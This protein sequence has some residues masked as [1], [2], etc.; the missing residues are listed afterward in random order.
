MAPLCSAPV[1]GCPVGDS[2]AP[3]I[4][5]L[6]TDPFLLPIASSPSQ[7]PGG[8]P[9]L[10]LL[11]LLFMASL[12]PGLP[13][14]PSDSTLSCGCKTV[15]LQECHPFSSP[16]LSSVG[17]SSGKLSLRVEGAPPVPGTKPDTELELYTYLLN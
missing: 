13:I 2:Q 10:F 7:V 6:T 9:E 14:L 12:S 15:P 8:Q 4:Q 17:R 3:R 16:R 1:F 5:P 11:L